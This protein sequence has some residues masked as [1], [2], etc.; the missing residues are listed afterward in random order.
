MQYHYK[1]IVLAGLLIAP[2]AGC[3]NLPYDRETQ[4]TAAGGAVGAVAGAALGDSMFETLLGGALGAGAGYLIGAH[5]DWFSSENNTA[6]ARQA[7]R[8]A[9]NDP[10]TAADVDNSNTADLNSDGFVTTDE[11]IAME[12]AGLSEGEIMNRVEATDQVFDITP[13]QSDQLIAAGVSRRVVNQLETV[14][15]EERDRLL[16]DA[17]VIGRPAE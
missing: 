12:E 9:Q 16:S 5:T 8:N 10:A 7:V 13:Q 15:R 2:L 17:S 14:N 11:L 4:A 6:E 3:E 1:E